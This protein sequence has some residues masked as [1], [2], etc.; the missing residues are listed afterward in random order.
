M[1]RYFKPEPGISELQFVEHPHSKNHHIRPVPMD[2]VFVIHMMEHRYNYNINQIVKF[3]E[4][5][6]PNKLII[7][8]TAAEAYIENKVIEEFE[9]NIKNVD[10][11]ILTV[12]ITN[13]KYKSHVFFPVHVFQILDTF[14][15]KLEPILWIQENVLNTK[16]RLKKYLFLN[17]HLR[18][19][20]FKIFESLYNNNK[21]NDGLVSFC[22]NMEQDGFN[23]QWYNVSKNDIDYIKNSNA[24]PLL[25]I[26]LDGINNKKTDYNNVTN[27]I[28]NPVFFSP[29]NTNI[30][31]YF[32]V[33][34]EIIT[35]GFSSNTPVHDYVDRTNLL[36]YSEKIWKPIL[37]GV[38]FCF[39]GPENTLEEF[40]K[41]FGFTFNCPLYYCN[42]GYD[43]NTFCDKV[44]EL[45]TLSYSELHK[46]YYQYFD[47]IRNNQHILINYIKNLYI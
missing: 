22:W 19:E 33:Y 2:N 3:V 1:I 29:P 8:F 38:P 41:A 26:E 32:N 27:E 35:E 25:P 45:S 37:F 47:E 30:T 21:L 20:R 7:D 6:K 17:H 46:L 18:T 13:N 44:N 14:G 11:K 36:H 42:V 40:S 23:A 4:K 10:L 15:D 39:W 24:Y 31:H 5:Y 28:Q 9:N 43:L 16:K 12:N 34:F